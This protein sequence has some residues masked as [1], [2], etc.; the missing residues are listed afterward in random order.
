MMFCH[1]ILFSTHWTDFLNYLTVLFIYIV[2]SLWFLLLIM[3]CS[4]Y[5]LC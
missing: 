2:H 5:D 4:S 3:M 1:D